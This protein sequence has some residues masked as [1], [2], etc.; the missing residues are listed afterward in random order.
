MSHHVTEPRKKVRRHSLKAL[1]L[2]VLALTACSG[3]GSYTTV[4]EPLGNHP[5][6][7]A[8]VREGNAF[9]TG[10]LIRPTKVI[11]AGHCINEVAPGDVSVFFGTDVGSGE[12][13]FVDVT[14]L[15][16][17]PDFDPVTLSND[18]GIVTLAEG[19]SSQDIVP[20]QLIEQDIT[21]A[22]IGSTL[23]FVGFGRGSLRRIRRQQMM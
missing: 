13:R 8:L 6:V 20:A 3:D 17:A 1:P 4:V 23:V 16:T 12:G 2:T 19:A 22:D 15:A 9:C 18:L 11:T 14:K 7:V 10:V 21:A 5:S